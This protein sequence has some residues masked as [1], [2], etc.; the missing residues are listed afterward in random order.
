MQNYKG[1][2]LAVVSELDKFN[3]MTDIYEVVSIAACFNSDRVVGVQ[4][5]KGIV[6]FFGKVE[7][8]HL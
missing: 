8:E 5:T 3:E 1:T 4:L 2:A 6:D 7:D